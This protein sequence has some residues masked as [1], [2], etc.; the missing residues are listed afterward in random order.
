MFC[1]FLSFPPPVACVPAAKHVPSC[2]STYMTVANTAKTCKDSE[3]C[4]LSLRLIVTYERSAFGDYSITLTCVTTQPAHHPH[5]C[6]C[7]LP[8]IY[9]CGSASARPPPTEESNFS[10][11][12]LSTYCT[13][14]I[15]AGRRRQGRGN[16]YKTASKVTREASERA[17]VEMLG[18]G[19]H[20]S[21]YTN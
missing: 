21:Y 16:R 12:K 8:S 6:M 9:Q 4:T 19:L 20:H 2:D 17:S 15:E 5:A 3:T 14:R 7:S 18:K 13:R 10:S 1:T 11:A